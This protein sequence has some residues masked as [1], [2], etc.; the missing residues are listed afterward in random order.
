MLAM[1]INASNFPY[2]IASR[3]PHFP[4]RKD[5]ATVAAIVLWEGTVG[6]IEEI[7]GALGICLWEK[8]LTDRGGEFLPICI[9]LQQWL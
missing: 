2:K 3:G 1:L 6:S 7:K 4:V 8:A 5:R 9:K